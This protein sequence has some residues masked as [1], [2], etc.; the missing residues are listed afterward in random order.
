MKA[1]G[2]VSIKIG[3]RVTAY[4][5]ISCGGCF[6]CRNGN[7]L[8]C[9]QLRV[10]G[11]DLDG[12][13][14]EFA[15][16]PIQSLFQVPEPLGDGVGALLEPLSVG[17]HAASRVDL[18]PTDAVLV[19]GAGTIGLVTA[20]AVRIQKVARIFVTDIAETRLALAREFGFEALGAGDPRLES[21]ILGA[22][23][24]EG[25]DVVFEC[26]G[27][28]PVALQMT[29][30]ARCRGVIVNVGVFK[31]PVEV[32]LQAVNFKELSLVGSRVYSRDAFGK[33]AQIAPSLRLEKLITIRLPLGRVSEAFDLLKS[34]QVGKVL[35]S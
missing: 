5:L 6:V 9:R 23:N 1:V 11:F 12:G 13:M 15:K 25:A 22:T 29:K 28:P 31:R 20:M 16:M 7:P 3:D 35:L 2:D 30:L 27:S 32:D 19:L 33:A 14:A 8:V 17:V 21:A 34:G 24:G 26:T 4:P 10:Y 18:N